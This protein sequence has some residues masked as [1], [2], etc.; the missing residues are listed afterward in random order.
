MYVNTYMC[1]QKGHGATDATGVCSLLRLYVFGSKESRRKIMMSLS[2]LVKAY[3]VPSS[4]TCSLNKP[5]SYYK[6]NTG[7]SLRD[8]VLTQQR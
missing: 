2:H 4:S 7:L 5:L 1:Q 3:L 8:I 6:L